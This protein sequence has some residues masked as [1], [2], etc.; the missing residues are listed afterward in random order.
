MSL[1]PG[2]PQLQRDGVVR[3]GGRGGLFALH[4]FDLALI[5]PSPPPP[6]CAADSHGLF[7]WP[8]Q[9]QG[10]ERESQPKV[11]CRVDLQPM[12]STARDWCLLSARTGAQPGRKVPSKPLPGPL[13]P[14]F[15]SSLGRAM[16]EI[17]LCE[18]LKM[19]QQPPSI[20]ECQAVKGKGAVGEEGETNFAIHSHTG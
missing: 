7:P 14:A 16:A 15:L 9:D 13:H 3:D 12:P 19:H 6:L 17:P 4:P 5:L 20:S 18:S 10:H 1:S 8:G 2:K 11:P